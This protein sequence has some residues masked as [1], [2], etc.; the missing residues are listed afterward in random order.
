MVQRAFPLID[1]M[2]NRS[3]KPYIFQ[4]FDVSLIYDMFVLRLI[5]D[6]ILYRYFFFPLQIAEGWPDI[7]NFKTTVSCL[8]LTSNNQINSLFCFIMYWKMTIPY[9]NSN[10]NYHSSMV[11]VRSMGYFH[12][13]VSLLYTIRS[14][15]KIMGFAEGIIAGGIAGVVVESALYPI[16]TIKTRLQACQVY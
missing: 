4:V 14:H 2:Q 15:S 3:F 6:H 16:D 7:L 10:T 12:K 13:Y 8:P 11:P 9:L 1:Q 5:V